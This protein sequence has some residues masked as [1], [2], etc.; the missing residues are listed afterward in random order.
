MKGFLY[1]LI[2]LIISYPAI[3]LSNEVQKV[4]S[5]DGQGGLVLIVERT[6]S[7]VMV[8]DSTTH[9][10]L[11][12]VKGLGNL[13]HGTIKFS[14]NLRY[15]Y[16]ISRDAR[17][18]KIDLRSLKVVKSVKAGEDSV[19]GVMTQDGRYLAL[20]NYRPGGVKILD[21]DT[22][23][24]VKSIPAVRE[25]QD[26]KRVESRVVGLVDAPDNLLIFSL[27]DADGIWIIDAGRSDFPVIKKFWDVGRMPYDALITPDGRYYIAGI[28]RSNWI[29]LLDL[30]TDTEVKGVKTHKPKEG[31]EVPLWK[32]PHPKGWAISGDYAVIPDVQREWVVV[33]NRKDFSLIKHIPLKGTA[34]Y[35]V[36]QPG[37]RYVWVD[38]IGKNGDLIQ[39]IDLKSLSVIKTLNPGP[40]ATHPQFTAK[41]EA[42]YISLMDGGKV[43]IYDTKTFKKI[44]EFPA[45]HPSG[46][47]FSYRAYKFGM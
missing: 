9:T 25:Y 46:I 36:S 44:K 42:A 37:G 18:S 26:G 29:A 21:A 35:T 1:I 40:G 39:V 10:L 22:L 19:G 6:K 14:R 4:V 43:V 3:I 17:V 16:V 34:L 33:L 45:D 24:I 27:M 31:K 32:I 38:L 5:P 30:W 12:R 23:E 2:F 15:A 7:R 41:G 11:G 28:L 13:R 8:I 47:F 20:S